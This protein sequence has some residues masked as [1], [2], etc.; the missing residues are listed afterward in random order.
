MW[1]RREWLKTAAIGAAAAAIPRT[2]SA[3]ETSVRAPMVNRGRY[4]VAGSPVEYSSRA[5]ELVGRTTTLDMLSPLVL[6]PSKFDRWMNDPST[7]TAEDFARYKNSSINVFHIAVGIGGPDAYISTLK[8]FAGWNSFLAAHSDWFLRVDSP[9]RLAEVKKSGKVGIILG[10][11]DSEQFRTPADVAYFYSLGQRISQL[12]YNAQNLIGVGST[13]R[14]DS[15]ITDFGVAVIGQMNKVGMAVDVSHCGDKTT[16]DSFD[17]STKPVLFTHANCRA[18]NNHPR[19]KTDEAIKKM[20]AKGGVMGITGVRMFVKSSEPTTVE[21]LLNH[22]D[23]V[24]KLVG[25]EHVGVGSDIDLDGYDNMPAAE[26]KALRGGYKSAYAFRERDDIEGVN[27]PRRFCDIADGLIRR[28]YSDADIE[29]V[30][31][32]NF[33]RVL[34]QIWIA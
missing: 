23:H 24:A 25:I 17:I 33:Q 21:D 30:L 9:A 13:E 11:Q 26:H 15:G 12:T 7:F 29:G 6:S 14:E 31:G 10:L 34:G 22:Y 8:Y 18:L 5:L 16:L 1:N 2:L 4:S 19:C 20:A 3:A 27:H 28:G 32:G